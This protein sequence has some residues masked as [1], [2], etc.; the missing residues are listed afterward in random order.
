MKFPSK[1]NKFPLTEINENKKFIN[2]N[3]SVLITISTSK[4]FQSKIQLQIGSPTNIMNLKYLSIINF[5]MF[6]KI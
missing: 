4:K 3:Q 2:K 1:T 5:L 6:F